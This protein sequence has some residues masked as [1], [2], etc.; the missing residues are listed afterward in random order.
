MAKLTKKEARARR[1]RRIRGR[2]SGTAETPRLSVFRSGKHIYVQLIDDEQG[3]TLMSASTLEREFRD[4]KLFGNVAGATLIGKTIGERAVAANLKKVVFDR[5]GFR[6]AGCIKS[7][8][9]AARL[10][11]LEF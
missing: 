5:G 10:A 11:G 8:A 2:L 3:K 4:Q 1:H 7:L 9:D 6:Y